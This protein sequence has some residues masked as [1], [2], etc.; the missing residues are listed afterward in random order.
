M[1]LGSLTIGQK[2]FYQLT[3]SQKTFGQEYGVKYLLVKK[4]LME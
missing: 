2:A 4:P 1:S 3:F